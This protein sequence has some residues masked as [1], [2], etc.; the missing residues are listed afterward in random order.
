M[1]KIPQPSTQA[2][3]AAMRELANSLGSPDSTALPG[4]MAR[5]VECFE[6]LREGLGAVDA[7]ETRVQ[8]VAQGT[9]V[10]NYRRQRDADG[11]SVDHVVGRGHRVGQGMGGTK[12]GS[13][14]GSAGQVRT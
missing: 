7:L 8:V 11:N 13:F 1:T 5:Q 4:L 9:V 12:H 3:L 14:D 2:F 6:A 10:A